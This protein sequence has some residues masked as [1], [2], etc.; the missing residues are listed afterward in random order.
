M[1]L[2]DVTPILVEESFFEIMVIGPSPDAEQHY[3]CQNFYR[4]KKLTFDPHALFLETAAMF[5]DKSKIFNIKY[6]QDT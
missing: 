1:L 3:P 5:Y 2:G 4:L 6:L